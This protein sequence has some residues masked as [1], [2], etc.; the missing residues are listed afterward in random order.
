MQ[1][2]RARR[3][4]YIGTPRKPERLVSLSGG[5]KTMCR[6][7]IGSGCRFC[8]SC[9]ISAWLHTWLCTQPSISAAFCRDGRF[10]RLLHL[11]GDESDEKFRL[12]TAE[13]SKSAK[14]TVS[15][16]WRLSVAYK[17]CVRHHTLAWHE[18]QKLR[19]EPLV[20]GTLFSTAHNSL[21]SVCEA[22][23]GREM[24][25]PNRFGYTC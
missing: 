15:T 22:S 5:W 24:S 9:R 25:K 6:P 7:P 17:S 16:L 23:L 11:G 14:P 3:G 18:G 12:I 21:L 1:H 20:T 8:L 4:I 13:T 10:G 19:L 2:E